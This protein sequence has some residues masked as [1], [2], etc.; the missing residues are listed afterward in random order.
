TEDYW[1]NPARGTLAWNLT[2]AKADLRVTAL[3]RAKI[4]LDE[5]EPK[6]EKT[7]TLE[8]AE[9]WRLRG[10]WQVQTGDNQAAAS[11]YQN[12]YEATP[13]PKYRAAL[14]EAEIRIRLEH[15]NE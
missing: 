5:A 6:L 14:V 12:A 3:D 15:D 11:S 1:V 8:R 7:T 10:N 2:Q 13:L 9:Y 4:Q